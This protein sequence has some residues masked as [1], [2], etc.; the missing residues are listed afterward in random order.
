MYHAHMSFLPRSG[1]CSWWFQDWWLYRQEWRLEVLIF[2]PYECP[3]SVS[4]CQ[5]F[6][7]EKWLQNSIQKLEEVLTFEVVLTFLRIGFDK[8]N[9]GHFCKVN[10]LC[11]EWNVSNGSGNDGT[12][13]KKIQHL[14]S[15]DKESCKYF[16]HTW[17]GLV[18]MYKY[19]CILYT[20]TVLYLLY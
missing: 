11:V 2:V 3:F 13:A 7:V 20:T 10:P 17:R 16:K 14:G 6:F 18:H 12:A 9:W 8:L 15:F 4:P 5:S 1:F 19:A